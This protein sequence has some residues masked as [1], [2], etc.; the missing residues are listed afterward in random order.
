MQKRTLLLN[1]MPTGGLADPQAPLRSLLPLRCLEPTHRRPRSINIFPV[2]NMMPKF[3]WLHCEWHDEDDSRYQYPK[4]RP[5][6]GP[7]AFPG[8]ISIQYNSVSKRELSDTI[9]VCHRDAFLFDGSK[10]NKSISGITTT[11]PG[12]HH[13]WRGPRIAYGKVA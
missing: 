9:Y 12:Q 13:D 2:R 8:H 11:T 7:Q 5:L 1:N 4:T 3:N 10:T 6:L